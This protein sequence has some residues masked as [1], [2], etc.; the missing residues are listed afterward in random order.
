MGDVEDSKNAW[1]K[2]MDGS[3]KLKCEFTRASSSPIRST[4]G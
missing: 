1:K 2:K 3:E 4:V